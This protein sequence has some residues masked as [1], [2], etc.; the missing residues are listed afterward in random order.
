[1]L[2]SLKSEI[3]IRELAVSLVVDPGPSGNHVFLVMSGTLWFTHVCMSPVMLIV[4]W[5]QQCLAGV[6]D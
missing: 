4:F 6:L 1:M 2:L 3:T 5:H